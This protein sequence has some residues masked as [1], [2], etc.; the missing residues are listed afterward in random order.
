MKAIAILMIVAGLT[1]G[2]GGAMEFRYFG[3]GTDQF[4]AGLMAAPGGLIFAAAGVA[5]WRRGRR[6]RGVVMAAALV[7][8]TATAGATALRVMGPPAALIGVLSSIAALTYAWR[9][10]ASATA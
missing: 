1:L 3:P 5:L 8:L 4:L 6:A 7:M 9:L 10:N 2:W